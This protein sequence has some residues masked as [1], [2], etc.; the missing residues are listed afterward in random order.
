MGV[1]A[2]L[3]MCDVVKKKFTFAISSPDEFLSPHTN[4]CSTFEVS[5]KNAL[6]KCGVFFRDVTAILACILR[7]PFLVS[8]LQSNFFLFFD[9]DPSIGLWTKVSY[10]FFTFKYLAFMNSCEISRYNAMR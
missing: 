1:G 10:N 2:G 7:W 6:Y 4:T 5:Y 8:D 9:S 3:Y